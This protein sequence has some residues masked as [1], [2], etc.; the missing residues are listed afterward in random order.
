[1]ARLPGHGRRAPPAAGE[2]LM[3]IRFERPPLWAEIDAK[4]HVEGKPV[5]FSW[6]EIIY[7]PQHIAIPPELIIHEAAHGQRQRNVDYIRGSGIAQWWLQYIQDEDFRYVEELLAHRAEYAFL[8]AG[9]KDRN[10]L[11]SL[12]VR[13][14]ARLTSP[15]YGWSRPIYTATKEIAPAGVQSRTSAR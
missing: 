7:N 1:M 2:T 15:L 14:A 5:I 12:L 10:K 9:V 13:T 4:F 6:G 3:E 11:N 8:A